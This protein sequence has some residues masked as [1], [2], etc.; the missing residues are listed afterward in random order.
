MKPAANSADNVIESFIFIS[1]SGSLN[2]RP[3]LGVC[4]S[5]LARSV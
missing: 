4:N 1:L 5:G 3:T 2:G